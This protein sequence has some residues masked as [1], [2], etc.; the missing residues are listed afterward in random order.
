METNIM[1]KEDAQNVSIQDT[2]EEKYWLYRERLKKFVYVS[3]NY[4]EAGTN[5]PAERISD[6][7]TTLY[8]DDGNG[9]FNHYLSVL[10]TEYRLL[11]NQGKDYSQTIKELFYALKS[12]ERLD[13]GAEPAFRPDHSSKPDALNGFFLRNDVN[14]D[15]WEKYKSGG[16][17]SYFGQTI[18]A[19]DAALPNSLDNC[20]HLLESFSLINALVD[21]E[22]VDGN[23]VDFKKLARDNTYRIINNMQHPNEPIPVVDFPVLKKTYAYTWY[24][25]NTVTG[26]PV[27]MRFGSGL[28]GTMI[29]VSYGLKKAANRI[30]E[31]DTFTEMKFGY[32]VCKLILSNPVSEYQLQLSA[33]RKIGILPLPGIPYFEY[34][35][36]IISPEKTFTINLGMPAI[37]I[38]VSTDSK[39]WNIG[40]DDYKVRSL[41]ATGNMD[42]VK[43]MNPYQVLFK[44]QM[45][46]KIF[47]YEHFPLIWA[48]VTN[49]KSK[50]EDSN[51][52]Y[53]KNLLD[54]APAEGPY[55]FFK[56]N[57]FQYG[58]YEWSSTSRLVWPESLGERNNKIT[59][60]FN[61]LDYMLLYNLYCLVTS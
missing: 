3:S 28:D 2:N 36:S 33:K 1:F 27:P 9:A 54:S 7:E 4:D 29:Y 42:I 55:K 38:T 18:A 10:A 32:E 13:K 8:W 61:G 51:K 30:L 45:E 23:K 25:K 17:Q 59:G 24:I 39:T 14:P 19:Y 37:G 15:F 34:A 40:Q 5:I 53:I 57:G 60:Y 21:T 41:C 20:I 22:T 26:E 44:K 56:N 52:N 43:K 16:S 6:D 12:F 11:K 47:K 46:S 50:V 58:S 35:F 48:V 31:A 49:N